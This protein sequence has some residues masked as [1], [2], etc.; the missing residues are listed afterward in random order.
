MNVLNIINGHRVGARG[1]M[2]VYVLEHVQSFPEHSTL[3]DLVIVERRLSVTQRELWRT[4][5]QA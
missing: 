2:P 5:E 1:S 3:Q 4:K